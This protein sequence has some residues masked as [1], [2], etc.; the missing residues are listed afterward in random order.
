MMM[1]CFGSHP[2]VAKYVP[3]ELKEQLACPNEP[4][5]TRGLVGN[6]LSQA[7]AVSRKSQG[8]KLMLVSK[9]ETNRIFCFFMY[10][11]YIIERTR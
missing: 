1:L 7:V 3:C 9:T 11:L 10:T 5:A 2:A 6:S 8:F 4:W